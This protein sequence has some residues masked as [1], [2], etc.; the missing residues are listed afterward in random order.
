MNIKNVENAIILGRF[1]KKVFLL[2]AS[3]L[4]TGN[5]GLVALLNSV[6]KDDYFYD[7]KYKLIKDTLT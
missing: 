3:I 2:P 1:D 5:G 6:H 7:I 4:V